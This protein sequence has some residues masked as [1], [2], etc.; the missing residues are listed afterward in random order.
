[1]PYF[2]TGQDTAVPRLRRSHEDIRDSDRPDLMRRDPAKAFPGNERAFGEHDGTPDLHFFE[3]ATPI[4]PV[5]RYTRAQ[6]L[7]RLH[8]Y[9]NMMYV[10]AWLRE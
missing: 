9:P 3:L 10:R 6:S 7:P 4:L 5:R 8:M 2:R 1:M